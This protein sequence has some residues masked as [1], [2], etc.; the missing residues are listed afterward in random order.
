MKQKSER[1]PSDLLH[2]F[3][4][5]HET[6]VQLRRT[7]DAIHRHVSKKL[8]QWDLSV[9]KYGVLVR[10]Y[11]HKEL[12]IS[13]LSTQIFRGNSNMTTLINRLEKDGLVCRGNGDKDRRV[14]MI[15]LTPKGLRLAPVVIK[16]YRAFQPATMDGLSVKERRVL[17]HLLKKVKERI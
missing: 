7:H 13:Y 17:L 5:A 3:T 15:R 1:R 14:T 16:E 9:P 8:A 10:V 2:P 4:D 6:Y 11:D 12:S